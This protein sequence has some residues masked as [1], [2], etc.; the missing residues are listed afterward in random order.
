MMKKRPTRTTDPMMVEA[1]NHQAEME[2]QRM[3]IRFSKDFLSPW[4]PEVMHDGYI[5]R[6]IPPGN[7]K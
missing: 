5:P 4:G 6:Q 3:K 7:Q 1:L 2:F